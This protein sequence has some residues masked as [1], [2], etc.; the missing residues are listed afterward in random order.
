MY[1]GLVAAP[2]A[3]L[4]KK[5]A[6]GWSEQVNWAFEQ[7]KQAMVTLPVLALP[8]FDIPFIIETDASGYGVDAVLTQRQRPI[9]CFSQVLFDRARMKSLYEHELMDVVLAVQ[10]GVIC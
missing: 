5:D 6:F 10:N 8:D 7:L 3:Q 4:L 1:Y 2:L 9:T